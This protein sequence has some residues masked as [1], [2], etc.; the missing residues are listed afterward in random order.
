MSGFFI[1][2]AFFF[3]VA[4]CVI[5]GSVCYVFRDELFKHVTK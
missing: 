5:G 3:L 2:V 4:L 1:G